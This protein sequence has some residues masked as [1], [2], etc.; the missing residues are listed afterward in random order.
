MARSSREK[1]LYFLW[2][3]ESFAEKKAVG[4][5]SASSCCS[6]IAPIPASDASVVT[7]ILVFVLMKGNFVKFTN[8]V[9]T[10]WNACRA[11]PSSVTGLFF[12]SVFG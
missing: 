2:A 6:T 9:L 8:T 3:A 12:H 4:F 7:K 1:V 10:N 5:R 11:L